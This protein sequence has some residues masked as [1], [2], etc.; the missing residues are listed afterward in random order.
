MSDHRNDKYNMAF[1]TGGLFQRETLLVVEL[2]TK[3]ADWDQIKADVIQNNLF[4]ARTQ[5]SM[6]R[7]FR[8]IRGRLKQLPDQAIDLLSQASHQEQLALLWYAVCRR[9]SFLFEFA[10]E[11]IREKYLRLQHEVSR[12]DFFRFFDAKADWHEE[13]EAISESTRKK[14]C[15]V[16]F[17]ML[18]EAGIL[19]PDNL[20][21]PAL[22][23][24]AVAQVIHQDDADGVRI[25]PISDLDIER[26][27][28]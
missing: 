26:C 20:I 21:V 1:S 14:L 8:E 4:Q 10:V 6:E 11:V 16:A 9:H 5:A 27:L 22:L 19:T 28:Y 24:P 7:H 18:R 12:D 17:R 3:N 13:L 23:S 2:F 15:Q 25:F